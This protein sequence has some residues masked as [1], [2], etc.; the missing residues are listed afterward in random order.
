[1]PRFYIVRSALTIAGSDSSGGAGIQA[2][3]KTFAALGVY[4]LSAITAITAQ[5]SEGVRDIAPVAPELV[6][7]Q[8][9]AVA[10]D[11]AIDAT[12][13]G[14]LATVS[15][16]ESVAEILARLALKHVVL[17]PVLTSTSGRQLLE[18]HGVDVLRARLLPLV[19]VVT[20]NVAEAEVLTGLSVRSLTDMH[21]A[22][23]RLA[24]L[25]ARAVVITGGHLDGPPIDVVWESGTLTD[26]PG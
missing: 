21:R 8:V 23:E 24:E 4:G 1:M 6:A 2:D 25:G 12:K 16:V 3:L 22:A 7:A 9:Q 19:A 26:I 5:N 15:I 17:D 18:T 20:P 11:F 14:M 13:I 10:D